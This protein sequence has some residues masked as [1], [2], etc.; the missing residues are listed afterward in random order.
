MDQWFA[1]IVSLIYYHF[2]EVNCYSRYNITCYNCKTEYIGDS[3]Q[4]ISR[5]TPRSTHY[6]TSNEILF[7]RFFNPYIEYKGYR[8]VQRDIQH[9]VR[10]TKNRMCLRWDSDT[11]LWLGEHNCTLCQRDLCNTGLEYGVN[12]DVDGFYGKGSLPSDDDEVTYDQPVFGTLI[13]L[14]R[15]TI[16]RVPKWIV[17]L[18]KSKKIKTKQRFIHSN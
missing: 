9:Y 7:C 15:N 4:V 10:H 1:L 2:G 5:L 16:L 3:C 18:F 17:S 14:Y 12:N 6:N 8:P 13:N 11:F